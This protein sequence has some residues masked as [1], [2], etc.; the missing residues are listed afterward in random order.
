MREFRAIIFR[1]SGG[2]LKIKTQ[3]KGF[4]IDAVGMLPLGSGFSLFAKVGFISAKVESKSTFT[5]S[6]YVIGFACPIQGC[7][8]AINP[9]SDST[10]STD[11]KVLF[12]LGAAYDINALLNVRV[13]VERYSKLGDNNSTGE[14]DVDLYSAGIAYKF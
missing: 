13:E 10:S 2:A 7:P 3:A 12:G 1:I 4:N 11:L 6:G 9:A 14:G 8:S 5:Q